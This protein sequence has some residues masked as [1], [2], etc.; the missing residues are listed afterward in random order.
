MGFFLGFLVQSY[1]KMSFL[2]VWIPA[3][4]GQVNLSIEHAE[5]KKTLV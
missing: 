3:Q 5:N 1:P 4:C 2:A